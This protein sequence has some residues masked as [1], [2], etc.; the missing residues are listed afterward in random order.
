MYMIKGPQTDPSLLKC[1]YRRTPVVTHVGLDVFQWTGASR[2][3][4]AGNMV[5]TKTKVMATLSRVDG[6]VQLTIWITGR[7]FIINTDSDSTPDV[8]RTRSTLT[9]EALPTSRLNEQPYC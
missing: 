3:A 4:S 6:D 7:P 1:Q 8:G 9:T 5:Q 2:S